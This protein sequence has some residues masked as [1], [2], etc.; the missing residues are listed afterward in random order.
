MKWSPV[1]GLQH[2]LRRYDVVLAESLHLREYSSECSYRDQHRLRVGPLSL[3]LYSRRE[4]V[5]CADPLV[6]D[7]D[8]DV[9]THADAETPLSSTL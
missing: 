4:R 9:T 8:A 3:A 7:N 6:C 5:V 2:V 1:L